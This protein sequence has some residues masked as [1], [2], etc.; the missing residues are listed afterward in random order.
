MVVEML[1]LP[2]LDL[3]KAEINGAK[4]KTHKASPALWFG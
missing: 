1:I 3:L 4:A 2:F